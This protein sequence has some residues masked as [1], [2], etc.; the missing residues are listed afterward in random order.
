M[1]LRPGAHLHR[2]PAGC[3]AGGV[4]HQV[5]H[6]LVDPLPVGVEDEVGRAHVDGHRHAAGMEAGFGRR[7]LEQSVHLEGTPLQRHRT[8]LQAG[9]PEDLRDQP[10]Q[11]L[12][13]AEHRAQ[14]LG[15]GRRHPVDQVL[16]H[17]LQGGDGRAQL[18][19]DV[20]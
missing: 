8:R 12:D 6:D 10:S 17:G 15:I 9:Q 7:L 11:A 3:V 2:R 19:G 16:E 20:G 4:L 14:A 13:L 5:G 1:A 18:V